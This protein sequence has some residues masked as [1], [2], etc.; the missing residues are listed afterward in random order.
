MIQ[1]S[2]VSS[3]TLLAA[4]FTTAAVAA[5]AQR[6]LLTVDDINALHA[7]SDPQLSP[8][9]AWVAY[10]VGTSDPERD[11][12]VTHLWMASWD[13][14]RAVQ[15][16]SSKESEHTPR[17]SPDGR[18]LSFLT[19][20]NGEDEPDQLWLLDRSGGEAQPA[21]SFNGDV[22]DY[23]WSPDGKRLALIVMDEDPARVTEA[24][25]DKTPPPIVIDRYYFK[26]DES[27]YLGALRKHLY[28]F[29]V[30]TRKTELADAGIL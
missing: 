21:T 20:R 19:A 14:K 27:G 24:S 10:S 1:R 23:E 5:D 26:E 28:V 12:Y 7:V 18:Y 15:L 30:D 13:G 2:F 8:D 16:T 25:K 3:L 4:L 22:L 11:E 6:R 9:G 17:W 29:D